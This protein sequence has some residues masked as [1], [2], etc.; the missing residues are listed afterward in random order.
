MGS[1]GSHHMLQSILK[2]LD[3]KDIQINVSLANKEKPCYEHKNISWH[4]FLPLDV[5]CTAADLVICN[6]GSPTMYQA[7][8]S[9]TPVIGIPSNL[10]QFLCMQSLEHL[11]SI[12]MI[13]ADRM[14]IRELRTTVLSMLQNQEILR[15]A[16]NLASALGE[17]KFAPGFKNIVKQYGAF[18]LDIAS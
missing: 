16:H 13:R 15:D 10:D 4:N 3:S 7:L 8:A 5:A 18:Q 6:G 2:A 11:T 9:G 17:E 14:R 1:S 12:K